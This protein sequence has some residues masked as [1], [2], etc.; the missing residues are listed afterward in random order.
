MT[1]EF[2]PKRYLRIQTGVLVTV[3]EVNHDQIKETVTMVLQDPDGALI[4]A[5][6]ALTGEYADYAK[7]TMNKVKKI[8][9]IA[10]L[11]EAVGKSIGIHIN[12]GADFVY[13]K[14]PKTGQKGISFNVAGYFDAKNL[15]GSPVEG[16]ND[17]GSDLPF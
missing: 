2:A 15:V 11:K 5:R 14:G 10:S 13:R 6:F 3:K 1:D 16:T 17:D 8:L 12:R 7:S 4:D 9:N